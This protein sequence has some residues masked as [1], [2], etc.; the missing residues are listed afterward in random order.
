MLTA[1]TSS[2]DERHLLK[3]GERCAANEQWRFQYDDGR[4]ILL[5]TALNTKIEDGS[6]H[7]EGDGNLH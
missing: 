2:S 5:K 3:Q 6:Q 4:R 7:P 1:L